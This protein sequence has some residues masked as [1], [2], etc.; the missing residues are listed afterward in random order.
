MD[1]KAKV[2][3]WRIEHMIELLNEPISDLECFSAEEFAK[4]KILIRAT[5][6][7]IIKIG[8]QMNRLHELFGHEYPQ[9]SWERINQ[10]KSRI[11]LDGQG[12]DPTSIYITSSTDLPILLH[13]WKTVLDSLE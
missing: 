4:N 11:S 2:K 6:F 1:N 3:R 5:C 12:I 10:L 13:G 9:I 8:E 7:S